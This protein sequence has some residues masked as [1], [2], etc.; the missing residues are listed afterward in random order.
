MSDGLCLHRPGTRGAAG[1]LV[2]TACSSLLLIFLAAGFSSAAAG[3]DVRQSG[4][5][6]Q[7]LDVYSSHY[8]VAAV[9]VVSP[10]DYLRLV[11]NEMNMA[12]G[13][14]H[15]ERGDVF[16]ADAV[17]LDRSSITERLR[18][19]ALDQDL[20]L[21]IT[22]VIAEIADCDDDARPPTLKVVYR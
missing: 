12:L 2:N 20:P 22:V 17:N 3:P 5:C 7:A 6:T 14:S 10:F 13:S 18:K 1:R 11:R 4:N 21:T 8:S 19:L 15:V 16:T 9:D